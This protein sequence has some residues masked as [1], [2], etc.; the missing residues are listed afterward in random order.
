VV[1]RPAL[2]LE[3]LLSCTF[4]TLDEESHNDNSTGWFWYLPDLSRVWKHGW[5]AIRTESYGRLCRHDTTPPI[6]CVYHGNIDRIFW[7][8]Q[9]KGWRGVL[10]ERVVR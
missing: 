7:E 6:F 10:V 5:E 2:Y 8:W 1:N 9:E 3:V 4:Y